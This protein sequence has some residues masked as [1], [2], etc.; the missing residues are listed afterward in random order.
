MRD[1]TRFTKRI[2]VK[3]SIQKLY[4]CW[5][6]QAGLEEWFLRSAPFFHTDKTTK[7]C[8]EHAQAGDIYEWRWHGWGEEVAETGTVVEANDKDRFVFTFGNAGTVI[9]SITE[10]YGHTILELQQKNIPTDPDS[11]W[12]YFIGCQ[13]GWTFYLSNLKSILEGG[14]DL[15]NRDE[16]LKSVLNM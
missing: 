9:V 6:T 5:A 14:I 4:D 2:A 12:N 10:Q 1:Y 13:T 11:T 15:R 8:N 3:A 7:G 16:S